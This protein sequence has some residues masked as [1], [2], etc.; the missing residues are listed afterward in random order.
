MYGRQLMLKAV[1]TPDDFTPITEVEVALT[2]SIAPNNVAVSQ[3][4]EPTAPEYVRQ[5]Y[6]LDVAHWSPTSFG[7]LY[8]SLTLTWPQVTVYWG[9][10]SG[11]A[12]I[13]PVANQVLNA[14]ALLAPFDGALGVVPFLDPGTLVLGLYD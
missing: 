6:P 14:G 3:L 10:V 4:V 12:I 5:P 13:E 1:Y 7:E 11:W 8:N 2:R 9:W